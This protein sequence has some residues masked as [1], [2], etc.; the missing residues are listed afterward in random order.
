VCF[1]GDVYGFE[2]LIVL[3]MLGSVF[4]IGDTSGSMFDVG[5]VFGSAS[6]ANKPTVCLHM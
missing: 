6:N 5:D 1:I 3:D 4:D 2:A